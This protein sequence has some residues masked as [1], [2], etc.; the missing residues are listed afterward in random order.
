MHLLRRGWPGV[1]RGFAARTPASHPRPTHLALAA[2]S[3]RFSSTLFADS[4]SRGSDGAD[5]FTVISSLKEK[6]KSL[7]KTR[8]GFSSAYKY[9]EDRKLKCK[10]PGEWD[11]HIYS[12]IVETMLNQ[13]KRGTGVASS[14][15]EIE[16]VLEHMHSMGIAPEKKL[17][18]DLILAYAEEDRAVTKRIALT[19]ILLQQEEA[20]LEKLEPVEE[21]QPEREAPKEDGKP[22]RY[23][24][25]T[26]AGRARRHQEIVVEELRVDLKALEESKFNTH[27]MELFGRASSSGIEFKLSILN[28][29]LSF[30]SRRGDPD[31]ALKYFTL[32]KDNGLEPDAVTYANLI[33]AHGEK[34]DKA[35]ASQW[36]DAYRRSALDT[37]PAPYIAILGALVKGGDLTKSK[38]VMT[39]VIPQDSLP[40]T[41]EILSSYM[42][43]LVLNGQFSEALKW[44]SYAQNDKENQFP[45]INFEIVDLAFIAAVLNGS[46]EQAVALFPKTA[47][48]NPWIYVV[49]LLGLHAL[50]QKEL[51]LAESCFKWICEANAKALG[52]PSTAFVLR[53][54]EQYS[55][56][57]KQSEIISL[58]QLA[59]SSGL[60]PA[61]VEKAYVQSL[62]SI[63]GDFLKILK[64]YR[65]A[66]YNSSAPN[67]EAKIAKYLVWKSFEE[68]GMLRKDGKSPT[69]TE[70]DFRTVFDSCFSWPSHQEY[71]AKWSRNRVFM[72]LK[73]FKQRGLKMTEQIYVRVLENF[74][75]HADPQGVS[76]W[77]RAMR[78]AEFLKG[79]LVEGEYVPLEQ[80]KE[81]SDKIVAACQAGDVDKAL[82]DFEELVNAKKYPSPFSFLILIQSLGRKKRFEAMERVASAMRLAKEQRPNL[83]ISEHS[84]EE[85]LAQGYLYGKSLSK[86]IE[87]L[88]SNT[89]NEK[90]MTP[91]I[92]RVLIFTV[93]DAI[94]E[95]KIP[96]SQFP[97]AVAVVSRAR[98]AFSAADN[99]EAVHPAVNKKLLSILIAGRRND[100]AWEVYRDM[101]YRNQSVDTRLMEGL[102]IELCQDG[103]HSQAM[104]V[105][106]DLCDKA[107]SQ[108]PASDGKDRRRRRV[109][110][111]LF[112][113]VIRS[114]LEAK[115]LKSATDVLALAT[116]SG[117]QPDAGMLSL[118]VRAT[119]EGKE[120]R[121][122]LK[123]LQSMEDKR[124]PIPSALITEALKALSAEST[125]ANVVRSF[126]EL[127]FNAAAKYTSALDSG[128]LYSST[129][130]IRFPKPDAE[131][132]SHL[133]SVA[134]AC[135]DVATAVRAYRL[136]LTIEAHPTTT[137]SNGLIKLLLTHGQRA[138]ADEVF[139]SMPPYQ[140]ALVNP[141]LGSV[142]RTVD[143]F[144][145]FLAKARLDQDTLALKRYMGFIEQDGI[146]TAEIKQ[147]QEK[148]LLI[149]QGESTQQAAAM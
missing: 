70:D 92:A 146:P 44:F 131:V 10:T 29:V 141:E 125:D 53:L 74:R 48:S 81:R 46:F 59:K 2:S 22:R 37:H 40:F 21:P 11:A 42:E 129:G 72:T 104:L 19:K 67:P 79:P 130:Q 50:E 108:P 65:A 26:E 120:F 114:L 113:I 1:C 23:P 105:L 87:I 83:K 95:D 110:T 8:E 91:R 122:C 96:S 45:K 80:L 9:F 5:G 31:M 77:I 54:I 102:L 135:G 25:V 112:N 86:A 71:N 144:E 134:I 60:P 16:V 3:R 90:A 93:F 66:V 27:A 47:E 4:H 56:N 101:L 126:G 88:D 32:I 76:E 139:L 94:Q 127:V 18:S 39:D 12:A 51:K 17:Y 63:K 99:Q 140:A 68:S 20:K 116:A 103:R 121:K 75:K 142:V 123:T 43:T 100:D 7:H 85:A 89:F 132:M 41:A 49:S 111:S 136:L 57:D 106:D 6:W 119:L 118:V 34:G 30:F 109:P 97:S 52:T 28:S 138:E 35:A 117:V 107:E 128:D 124:I 73:D 82:A 14:M 133:C 64:T 58:L 24:R 69:L 137:L 36:F 147:L 33:L 148:L 15:K 143:T 84:I 149:P 38:Y 62:R 98:Q 78:K 145:P 115:E 13:R 55:A 61:L